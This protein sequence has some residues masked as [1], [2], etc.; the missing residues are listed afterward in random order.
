MGKKLAIQLLSK[1]ERIQEHAQTY[2]GLRG[3]RCYGLMVVVGGFSL[4]Y[5]ELAAGLWNK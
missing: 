1:R 5:S 2:R 3:G 4:I